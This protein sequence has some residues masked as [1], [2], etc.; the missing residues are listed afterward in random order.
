M[1]NHDQASVLVVESRLFPLW[2]HGRGVKLNTPSSYGIEVKDDTLCVV[3][4]LNLPDRVQIG[5]PTHTAYT[6]L[7][8]LSW[9]KDVRGL[10]ERPSPT[11]DRDQDECG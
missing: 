9:G 11:V 6:R 1:V 5:S 4:Q 8:T 2:Y 7:G 10:K 3:G